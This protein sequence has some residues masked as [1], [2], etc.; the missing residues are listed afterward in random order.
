MHAADYDIFSGRILSFE[1]D[2]RAN[3][4]I[5]NILSEYRVPFGVCLAYKTTNMTKIWTTLILCLFLGEQAVKASSSLFVENGVYSRVTIQ[6]EEQQQPENCVEYLNHLEV[7]KTLL[8]AISVANAILKVG[9]DW[10]KCKLRCWVWLKVAEHC[11]AS[12][13]FAEFLI[14]FTKFC[15]NSYRGLV[16]LFDLKWFFLE[17]FLPRFLPAWSSSVWVVKRTF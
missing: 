16:F 13:Y 14:S 6:I 10:D 15:S 12:Y 1:L 3:R 11:W 4:S 8:T 2:F 17:A 9:P 7:S 5:W